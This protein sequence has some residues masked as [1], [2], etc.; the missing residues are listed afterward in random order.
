MI[1]NV[2]EGKGRISDLFVEEMN[3]CLDCQACETACPAGVKYGSLVESARAVINENIETFSFVERF[4]KYFLNRILAEPK[5]LRHYSK[6][7][8]IYQKSYLKYL[9]ER[10]GLLKLFPAKFAGII[11]LIPQVSMKFS[12]D[13]IEEI[14]FPGGEI[15]YETAFHTGCI[16]NTAFAVINTDTI[17]VLKGYGC[18]V[19]T[20]GDQVC[21]G[22]LHAHNGEIEKARELAK[23]NIDMFENK[24]YDYL[25][26]N[27]AGCGA[28]MK[29]Y[30]K[31]LKNENGYSKRADAFS[32]KV[33]DVTE[34]LFDK[35]PLKKFKNISMHAAYHDACHLVHGQKIFNEPRELLSSIP[36]LKIVDLEDSTRCCGSAGIYNVLRYDDSMEI[37]EAKMGN[38]SQTGAETVI[39]GNPGC[40]LQISMGAEKFNTRVE[41]LHPVSVLKRAMSG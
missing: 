41:V 38:I 34:F 23:R 27:S 19:F 3:F 4:K 2:A 30:G 35:K 40:I 36:G 1:K 8:R 21:C 33:R 13:E 20:P 5:R 11:K 22:S 16:M 9:L 14:T 37:L 6:I 39:T 10:S 24:A 31:L 15:K 12:S 18:K 26:S 25:I 7:L 17:V 29:E 32:A 28:F